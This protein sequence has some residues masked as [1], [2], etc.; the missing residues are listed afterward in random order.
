MPRNSKIVGN[1]K[2]QSNKIENDEVVKSKEKSREKDSKSLSKKKEEKLTQKKVKEKIQKDTK[3]E[4][5]NSFTLRCKSKSKGKIK[6]SSK[7]QTKSVSKIKKLKEEEKKEEIEEKKTD[8]KK[9]KSRSKQKSADKDK[10]KEEDIIN[11]ENE[12]KTKDKKEDK[13]NKKESIQ[14]PKK[15]EIEEEEV[16]NKNKNKIKEKQLKKEEDKK[17]DKESVIKDYSG[18]KDDQEEGAKK[19][20][21]SLSKSLES[22]IASKSKLSKNNKISIGI[23]PRHL[24]LN[25]NNKKAKKNKENK[26]N[27]EKDNSANDEKKANK[28]LSN[29]EEEDSYSSSSL[30][31]L[32]IKKENYNFS[33]GL[34]TQRISQ[35]VEEAIKSIEKKKKEKKFSN[36]K[37]NRAKPEKTDNSQSVPRGNNHKAEDYNFIL[38]KN[39]DSKEVNSYINLEELSNKNNITYTDILLAIMEIGQNYNSYLFAYSS[40]SKM[41]WSDVLQ[42]KILKKIFSEFK[43]ET[44][45]KYWNELS[46]YDSENTLNLIKKNKKYLD[47]LPDIKLGTIVSTISKI[48][49]GKMKDFQ[50]KISKENSKSKENNN[51]KKKEI[52]PQEFHPNLNGSLTKIEKVKSLQ[53]NSRQKKIEKSSSKDSNRNNINDEVELKEAYH[54]KYP[55]LNDNHNTEDKINNEEN[56][57]MDYLK[58]DKK[59]KKRKLNEINQQEKFVFKCVDMV[60]EGLYKEFSN[61]SKDYIFEILQQNSMNISKTYICLKEPIKSKIIGYTSLDDKIILKMKKGE[62]FNNLLR[63]KGKKS[64]LEREDYLSK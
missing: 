43:A 4:N 24:K 45:R 6:V 16:D 34:E 20:L 63:E 52:H 50:Y 54:N 53:R 56:D 62:E 37:R 1:K 61:Y 15:M 21:K 36:K 42:Y 49:S 2:K 12:K 19:N 29:K 59:G 39:P 28:D 7:R 47:K 64:I 23:L 41:F 17:E 44:L 27:K 31:I 9:S 22:T 3:E 13:E 46:K 25:L 40:K 58:D 60:T 26:E 5:S 11:K 55:N 51:N 35:E 14:E 30:N 18:S 10:E 32:D 33:V 8:K 38:Q 48:L 57:E